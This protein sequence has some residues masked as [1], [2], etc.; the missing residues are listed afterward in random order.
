MRKLNVENTTDMLRFCAF[1]KRALKLLEYED[2]LGIKPEQES[3]QPGNCPTD[4]KQVISN[5][6]GLIFVDEEDSTVHYVHHSVKEHLLAS[7]RHS[8]GTVDMAGVDQHLGILCLTYLDFTDFKRQLAKVREGFSTPIQPVQLGILPLPSIGRK[9]ALDIL[10]RGRHLRHLRSAEVERQTEEIFGASKKPGLEHERQRCY[11]FLL[12]AQTHW[13]DH[14]RELNVPVG[15]KIWQLFCQCVEGSDIPARRPW[16]KD[17]ETDNQSDV[18][19]SEWLLTHKHWALLWYYA[20]HQPLTGDDD[21]ISCIFKEVVHR[22]DHNC[23]LREIMSSFLQTLR[24]TNKF[25]FCD[26]SLAFASRLGCE[27][28]IEY[29]IQA[30]G[31]HDTRI[32]QIPAF[33]AELILQAA[34]HGGHLQAVKTLIQ[35]KVEINVAPNGDQERNILHAAAGEGY[36]EVVNALE[37]AGAD[38]NAA[39]VAW[40]GRTALQAAAGGGHLEVVNALIRAGADINAAPAQYYGR[41]ALQA[42]AEAGHLLVVNA[43]LREN[44]DVNAPPGE[45]FGQFALYAAAKNG[46]LE[47]LNMLIQANADVNMLSNGSE[48]NSED[49][50]SALQ[51]AAKDGNLGIVRALIEANADVNL[52]PRHSNSK[53]ALEEAEDRGYVEIAE[54]LR[55]A[56]ARKLGRYNRLLR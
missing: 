52:V 4:M 53:T 30:G 22:L 17:Q 18:R 6:C 48:G 5:C 2:L 25:T 29:L 34:V 50:R 9:V 28:C 33:D 44:A 43:L 26:Y 35:A 42:A 14:L 20:I 32:N 55:Q 54:T 1:L 31:R 8:S 15:S 45:T 51:A 19:R 36:L 23:G 56:G 47:A 12:Y 38:I 21:L 10:S 40:N 3:H 37:K 27:V 11:P 13:I 46:H 7:N 41:T 49:R 39:P 24:W 16:D